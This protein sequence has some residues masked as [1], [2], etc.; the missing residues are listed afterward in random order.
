MM[1]LNVVAGYVVLNRLCNN[2]SINAATIEV[3]MCENGVPRMVQKNLKSWDVRPERHAGIVE[4]MNQHVL[5]PAKI[6]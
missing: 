6:Q 4:N 5:E 3:T 1:P 2:L